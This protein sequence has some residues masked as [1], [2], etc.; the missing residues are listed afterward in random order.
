MHQ[1]RRCPLIPTGQAPKC[2]AKYWDGPILFLNDGRTK[3]DSNPIE[4]TIRPITPHRT[5]AL[6]AGHDT[7]SQT[8][9]QLCR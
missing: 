9:P 8:G 7:G 4:H 3:M 2:I 5:Y 6:F 1:S